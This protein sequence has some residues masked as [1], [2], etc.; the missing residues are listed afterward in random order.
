MSGRLQWEHLI[1]GYFLNK[2][3]INEE[4]IYYVETIWTG[5]LKSALLS[6]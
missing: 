1:M 3:A 5:F 4:I 6:P 2:Y